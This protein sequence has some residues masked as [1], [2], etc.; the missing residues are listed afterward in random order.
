MP[1]DIPMGF[2]ALGV[3]DAARGVR[4]IWSSTPHEHLVSKP[5]VWAMP[6][7]ALWGHGEGLSGDDGFKALGVGDAARGRAARCPPGRF[8]SQVS[9]PLVWAM[10]RG[11]FARRSSGGTGTSFQSPW[12]GRCR[13]RRDEIDAAQCL[14]VQ[15]S[16]PSVW[17]MPRAAHSTWGLNAMCCHRVS[18]PLVWAMPRTARGHNL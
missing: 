16:K 3:G 11:W 14:I 2:K 6:R 8:P 9:K 13:A 1:A 5:L 15:V 10:P 17:A 7:A 12:C 4:G 18:K